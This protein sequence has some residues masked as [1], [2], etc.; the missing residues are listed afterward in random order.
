MD[1]VLEAYGTTKLAEFGNFFA[2]NMIGLPMIG[3]GM[4]TLSGCIQLYAGFISV[5]KLPKMCWSAVALLCAT[6][7]VIL[8]ILGTTNA[9]TIHHP[10]S[11]I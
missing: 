11:T 2:R 3:K 1:D 8:Q 9:S 7:Q 5:V 10:F 4:S 6:T